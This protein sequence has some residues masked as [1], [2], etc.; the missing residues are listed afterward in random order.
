MVTSG[1]GSGSAR[2]T[3]R[4]TSSTSPDGVHGSAGVPQSQLLV[5][6]SAQPGVATPLDDARQRIDITG[7]SSSQANP[8]RSTPGG[9]LYLDQQFC[10]N[11]TL[12]SNRNRNG[13]NVNVPR[14]FVDKPRSP[15]LTYATACNSPPW[16]V[17]TINTRGWH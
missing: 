11:K 10:N 7:Q 6:A 4:R 3:R 17:G 12:R 13:I 15:G 14:I 9:A 2:G 5:M 8:F 16:R 1:V